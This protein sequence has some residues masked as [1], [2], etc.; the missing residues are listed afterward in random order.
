MPLWGQEL[1]VNVD[2][3][4][5]VDKEGINRFYNNKSK[6]SKLEKPIRHLNGNNREKWGSNY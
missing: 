6:R 3:I 2:D 1:N 4:D 5:D